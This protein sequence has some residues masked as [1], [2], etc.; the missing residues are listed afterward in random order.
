MA[1]LASDKIIK[2]GLKKITPGI[3]V[4]SEE[5]KEVDYEIRSCWETLW[6]LDPLDG[7]KEFVARN[8]EFCISPALMTAILLLPDSY[9]LP[10]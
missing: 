2:A 4:F 7:T 8:D 5:T 1:D 3:P 9:T 6:I 10:S